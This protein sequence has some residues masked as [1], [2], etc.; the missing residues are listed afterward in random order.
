MILYFYVFSSSVKIYILLFI[1]NYDNIF[2]KL[3]MGQDL[4]DCCKK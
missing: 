4:S 3:R 2:Y 1:K